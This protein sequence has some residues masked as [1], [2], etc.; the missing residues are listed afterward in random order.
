MSRS[1]LAR[2]AVQRFLA[3]PGPLLLYGLVTAFFVWGAVY[4]GWHSSAFG[5]LCG[6]ALFF[7]LV[8]VQEVRY[9]LTG[10]HAYTCR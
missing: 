1:F 4:V 5:G 7:G 9:L 8:V 3:A 6:F 2:P 10:V